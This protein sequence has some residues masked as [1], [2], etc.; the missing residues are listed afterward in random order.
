MFGYSDEWL[1]IAE[2][3]PMSLHKAIVVAAILKHSVEYPH[4]AEVRVSVDAGNRM[5]WLNEVLYTFNELGF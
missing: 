3:P 2:P 4:H 5:L 1:G